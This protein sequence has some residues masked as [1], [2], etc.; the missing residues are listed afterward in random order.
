[1]KKL[2]LAIQEF[3]NDFNLI[4]DNGLVSFNA[5]VQYKTKDDI[6]KIESE[7]QIISIAPKHL[8]SIYILNEKVRD[9]KFPEMFYN[10]K[11]VISYIDKRC[12]LIVSNEGAIGDFEVF[13]FPKKKEALAELI[14]AKSQAS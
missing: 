1:M 12:L 2:S 14:K 4:K 9:F 6:K 10:G 3:V 5:I 11:S 8:D 13:I 7:V